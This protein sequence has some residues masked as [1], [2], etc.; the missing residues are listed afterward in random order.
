MLGRDPQPELGRG[1]AAEVHGCGGIAPQSESL[2]GS[3]VVVVVEE[4]LEVVLEVLEGL[5]ASAAESR[6]VEVPKQGL[7]EALAAAVGPGVPGFGEGEL[8]AETGGKLVEGV[9]AGAVLVSPTGR[10]V[11]GSVVLKQTMDTEV[12]GSGHEVML[13]EVAGSFSCPLCIELGDG[14][15]GGDVDSQV[16][17]DRSH[18]LESSDQEGVLAPELPGI[19]DLQVATLGTLTGSFEVGLCDHLAELLSHPLETFSVAMDPVALEDTMHTVMAH[20]D[21]ASQFVGDGLRPVTWM[22]EHVSQ[23]LRLVV[24]P[25][26]IPRTARGCGADEPLDSVPPVPSKPLPE[27]RPAGSQGTSAVAPLRLTAGEK[28]QNVMVPKLLSN[29][30][31]VQ[32]DLLVVVD[33][34][35]YNPNLRRREVLSATGASVAYTLTR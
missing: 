4:E 30:T 5:V 1:T 8:D 3:P 25:G 26:S 21:R 9:V 31:I 18:T 23:D 35:S 24:Q 16:V 33:G 17:V 12:L 13:E 28:R 10:G 27:G 2:M 6:L 19:G 32:R 22:D 11:F 29:S 15:A 7:V 20:R 34:I 14:E